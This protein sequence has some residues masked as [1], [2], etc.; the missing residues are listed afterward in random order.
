MFA[1]SRPKSAPTIP[2]GRRVYAIGDIHGEGDLLRQALQLIKDDSATRRDAT[3]TLVF[4]GDLI[5]RGPEAA[6]LLRTFAGMSEEDVVVLK[7]NHESAL[8]EAYRGDHDVLSQWLPF[9]AAATLA[10]FDVTPEEMSSGPAVLAGALRARIDSSFVEWLDGLPI[11]W[12]CGDYYFTHAG[13]RPG[14]KLHKQDERDLLWIREPF[15]SS[16]R[17]HGK[18]I[19][20]GHTVEPGIPSLGGNRIGVDT[21]AH[22]HG[23]LTVL[24]L[25]G[26]RQ[27]LLQAK[28]DQAQREW[29][30]E[31]EDIE[32]GSP[33]HARVH[34]DHGPAQEIETLIASIVTPEPRLPDT[35]LLVKAPSETGLGLS[36]SPSRAKG[37]GNSGF[38]A[39]GFALVLAAVG[40]A[41]A[42]GSRFSPVGTGNVT[43]AIPDV[44]P[45]PTSSTAAAAV[46][47][48]HNRAQNQYRVPPATGRRRGGSI[49][50]EHAGTGS[51]GR[52]SPKLYGAALERALEEDR[53]ITRRLNDDHLSRQQ[54]LPPSR[55]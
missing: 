37:L 40:G 32:S 21:G 6:D 20:H 15:L 3:V 2:P 19:V 49:T 18:V 25:E 24:G 23:V 22:E 1:R 27:W 13:I 31:P 47:P 9:G 7:G 52:P 14:V 5:D 12:E 53:V 4:L 43:I 36:S 45:A 26:G 33:M 35:A 38:A 54:P 28:A 50:L 41:I 39:A 51:A 11:A 10:G 8:V 30:F 29:N 42:F 55:N 34:R 44:S 48:T 16:R 46:T 17:W